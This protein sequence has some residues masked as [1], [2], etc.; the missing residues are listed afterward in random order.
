MKFYYCDYSILLLCVLHV[1]WSLLTLVLKYIVRNWNEEVCNQ[2]IIYYYFFHYFYYYYYILYLFLYITYY[3]FYYYLLLFAYGAN[4]F[5]YIYYEVIPTNPLNKKC[6]HILLS[7][8]CS[9]S[10]LL[11]NCH[12]KNYLIIW[13]LSHIPHKDRQ[14]LKTTA[15]WLCKSSDLYF[16]KLCSSAG[17]WYTCAWVNKR[18]LPRTHFYLSLWLHNL[19][20][21][22]F[23]QYN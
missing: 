4:Y 15:F 8:V 10:S 5:I 14:I 1:S 12:I 9:L 21:K 16:K 17:L 23:H 18:N 20:P 7:L 19:F 22:S 13:H 2:F 3:L 11:I 6:T